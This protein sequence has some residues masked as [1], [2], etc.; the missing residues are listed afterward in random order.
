MPGD[1]KLARAASDLR[2]VLG[3]LT[4]R[5]RTDNT[6]PVS[7]LAVLSR[8]DRTG[9]QTT[10]NLAAAEHMRPQ[11]MAEALADLRRDGLVERT[12]D[13]ADRRQVLIELT[14]RGREFLAFERRRREDWLSRA[15]ADELTPTEQALLVDAVA[16]LRRL[17]E[18]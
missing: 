9:P 7:H 3:Q 8:L 16:V 15:I 10:S 12:S 6:L 17:A 4:R 14:A 11:S 5:L 13:P 2:L 18:L 1:A